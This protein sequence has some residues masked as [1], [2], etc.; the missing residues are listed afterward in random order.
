MSLGS[1][2]PRPYQASRVTTVASANMMLTDRNR[3]PSSALKP[4]AGRTS[5]DVTAAV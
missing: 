5:V 2:V 4:V 1:H 3:V